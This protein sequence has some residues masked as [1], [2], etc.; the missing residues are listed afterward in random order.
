[1]KKRVVGKNRQEEGEE[2]GEEEAF[3]G[4]LEYQ[5][6]QDLAGELD[7]VIVK[8]RERMGEA[9][10]FVS[11]EMLAGENQNVSRFLGVVEGEGE[12]DSCDNAPQIWEDAKK[13]ESERKKAKNGGINAE[14]V[15]LDLSAGVLR[16]VPK[17]LK[18]AKTDEGRDMAIKA[19]DMINEYMTTERKQ[20]RDYNRKMSSELKI[21]VKTRKK[22]QAALG[23]LAM[24]E[25]GRRIAAECEDGKL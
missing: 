6:L 14:R 21:A 4:S 2:E 11:D 24:I 5:T 20:L 12:C 18:A 3:E 23:D 8:Y 1:M 22:V 7:R 19:M 25:I 9:I 10:Y 17:L 16:V 13:I 15:M